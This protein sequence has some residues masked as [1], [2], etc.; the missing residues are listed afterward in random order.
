MDFAQ[1]IDETVLEQWEDEKRAQSLYENS[2][3]IHWNAQ[4]NQVK[5][6]W[7]DLARS[8]K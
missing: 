6:Y 2:G 5:D 8:S 7:I 1:H 3:Y 4:P